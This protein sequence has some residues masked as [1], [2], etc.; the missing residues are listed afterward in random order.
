[1][2]AHSSRPFQQLRALWVIDRE[3]RRTQ[4]ALA[5]RLMIDPPAASRLVD[6]LVNDGLVIR[7][8]GDDRRCVRLEVTKKARSEIATVDRDIETIEASVRTVLGRREAEHLERMLAKLEAALD[9]DPR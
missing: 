6:R 1:M 9:V 5:D 8:A 3:D 4:A 7:R 2:G